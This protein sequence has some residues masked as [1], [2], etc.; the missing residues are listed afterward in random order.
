MYFTTRSIEAEQRPDAWR[1]AMLDRCGH[2][3]VE[4]GSD[5]VDGSVDDRRVGTL[6]GLRIRHPLSAA[7]R[8]AREISAGGAAKYKLLFQSAGA[9]TVEQDGRVVELRAGDMTLVDSRIPGSFKADSPSSV[10]ALHVPVEMLDGRGVRWENFLAARTPATTAALLHS[11]ALTSFELSNA[12]AAAQARAL[13]EYMLSVFS[14]G[15]LYAGAGDT[16]DPARFAGPSQLMKSIDAFIHTHLSDPMLGPGL[17]ARAH[18]IS[19]RQLHRLFEG[20][21]NSIGRSIRGQRLQRIAGELA[22]PEL[23]DRSITEIA[24][25]YGFVDAAHFSRAFKKQ[26]GLSP[27]SYRAKA[28]TDRRDHRNDHD[29]SDS[30][31]ADGGGP[32]PMAATG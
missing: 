32:E 22:D 24:F 7:Y 4:F 26:F 30:P 5:D 8:T 17:V 23:R 11:A 16:P 31:T 25:G 3:R 13:S 2:F 10:F 14:A 21:G 29:G 6:V 27:R 15:Y 20:V 18:N 28:Q 19:E 12:F 1:S 9:S